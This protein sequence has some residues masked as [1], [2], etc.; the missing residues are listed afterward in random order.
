MRRSHREDL[1]EWKHSGAAVAQLLVE[2]P[3]IWALR[4]VY[5]GLMDSAAAAVVFE[6]ALD[7]VDDSILRK[8]ED[9]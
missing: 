9:P 4:F 6:V 5:T 7:V 1:K 3:M 8:F 2:V